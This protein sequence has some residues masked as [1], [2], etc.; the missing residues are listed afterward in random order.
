MLLATVLAVAAVFAV[1][2]NRQV[3]DAD[4]WATTSTEL[5][6][7]EDVRA[8]VSGYLVDQVYDNVD[9]AAEFAAVL[10]PRLDPLA[11]PAAGA[12][13]GLAEDRAVVFLGRPAV[14]QAWARA[15]R[16]AAQEFAAIGEG[17]SETATIDGNAVVLDLRVLVSDLVARLGGS[18][19]LV[20][21]VPPDAGRIT[22]TTANDLGIL[23]DGV[24]AVRGLSALL[25]GL[26][27]ALFALAIFLSPGRR[28]WTLMLSGGCLM[29]AG[30]IVL[31][32]RNL[33][34]DRVVG[35]LAAT[36]SVEPAVEAVWG[37]GTEML[38]DVAQA[39]IV[40]GI[41]VVV[42]AWLAGPTRV[43]TS[44]R[45]A[46]SPWL[47]SRPELA[48]GALA[49]AILLVVAWGPIPATR[50]VLPVVLM[51]ALA[52]AGLEALRRQTA[53]EFPAAA[54]GDGAPRMRRGGARAS[55][56]APPATAATRVDQLERLAALHDHGALSDEEFAA[57]KRLLTG[58]AA[59][60]G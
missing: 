42:A 47:R 33:V 9:V 57:E 2:A 56:A 1:W 30:A 26:S 39:A 27:I 37:I 45:R 31:L 29:L 59:G 40:I 22:I 18:G 17:S 54:T 48:Y 21:K 8:G 20:A 10:P 25:P 16:V 53:A 15:N 58:M 49:A 14:Q 32:G 34:G 38:R 46:M 28:R 4:N 12:L 3:L 51:I 36:A 35:A 60:T 41:P 50:M 6:Q 43:A 44:L 24:A 7:D 23:Q 13:R 55:R 11:G 52:I 5:L 19:S